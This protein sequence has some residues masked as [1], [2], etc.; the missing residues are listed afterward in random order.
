MLKY[1]KK[2]DMIK[3]LANIG[4][5][6]QYILYAGGNKTYGKCPIRISYFSRQNY[7]ADQIIAR[8]DILLW[9]IPSLSQ[10]TFACLHYWLH[11]PQNRHDISVLCLFGM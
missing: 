2:H 9:N 4:D 7:L 6:C 1:W 3:L 11:K 5:E 10:C 8:Y